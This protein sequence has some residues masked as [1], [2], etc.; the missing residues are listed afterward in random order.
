MASTSILLLESLIVYYETIS[1]VLQKSFYFTYIQ[2]PQFDVI[3]SSSDNDNNSGDKVVDN[4][5]KRVKTIRQCCCWEMYGSSNLSSIFIGVFSIYWERREH[6]W[7]IANHK[8]LKG[9]QV[10]CY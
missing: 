5:K 4:S 2:L 7:N 1:V 10:F 8:K 3:I 6:V 9:Q